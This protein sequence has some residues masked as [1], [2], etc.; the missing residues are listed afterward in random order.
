[1]PEET[2]H[3]ATSLSE[4]PLS[5]PYK[6]GSI[7]PPRIEK[8]K[9]VEREMKAGSFSKMEAIAKVNR[10]SIQ[11][12]V[13]LSGLFRSTSTVDTKRCMRELTVD[14]AAAVTVMNNI[15]DNQ[16]AYPVAIQVGI[17]FPIPPAHPTAFVVP[18]IQACEFAVIPAKK[19]DAIIRNG[20]TSPYQD[21][22]L[23]DSSSF[24]NMKR[25][26]N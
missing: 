13:H 8:Y 6:E 16:G 19:K 10:Q 1:M 12:E 15:E 23:N 26:C 5:K 4:C 3:T 11:T 14:I 20:T 25:V 9:A 2:D 17:I 21:I 18:A 7:D 22:S 24:A